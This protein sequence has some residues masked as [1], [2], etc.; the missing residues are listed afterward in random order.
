M[1]VGKR[2]NKKITIIAKRRNLLYNRLCNQKLQKYYE[3][4]F[5]ND[6]RKNT[7]KD[8]RRYGTS[9]IFRIYKICVY[10]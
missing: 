7:A 2:L 4:G 3:G 6:K 8:E 9:R 5:V 10:V 1:V